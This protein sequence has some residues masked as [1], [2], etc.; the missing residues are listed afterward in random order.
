MSRPSSS[1]VQIKEFGPRLSRPNII[2]GFP[3]V[4]L[5]G[6]IASSYISEQL[7]L[8][9]HGYIDSDY[10]PPVMMVHNSRITYPIH[11][12]AKD[13][14]VIVLSEVPLSPRL[15]TEVAKEIASWAKSLK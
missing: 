5:V 14:T 6:T 3:E 4:G 12:M 10:M 11:I 7:G 15:A 9:A 8:V 2:V 13:D 1:R